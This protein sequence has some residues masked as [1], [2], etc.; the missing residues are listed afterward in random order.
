[1]EVADRNSVRVAVSLSH[2]ETDGPRSDAPDG[3]KSADCISGRH[4]ERFL[5]AFGASGDF[6]QRRRPLA[7]DAESMQIVIAEA[8]Q[9]IW[10]RKRPDVRPRTGR[11]G[12]DAAD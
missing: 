8:S 3:R 4:V 9:H 2:C 12:A 10:S 6:N 7:L 11:L 1:M 5:Q